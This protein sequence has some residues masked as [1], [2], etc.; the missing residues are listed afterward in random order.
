[1]REHADFWYTQQNRTLTHGGSERGS[2]ASIIQPL[3]KFVR[4]KF[5]Q[6]GYRE[7]CG[8]IEHGVVQSQQT[9]AH[10]SFQ[11][12]A[13]S[14]TANASVPGAHAPARR[15]ISKLAPADCALDW[16]ISS[17]TPRTSAGVT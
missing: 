12:G 2:T 15:G 7:G 11:Q 14:D 13:R 3:E 1:M 16:C 6:S 10:Q 9:L 17:Q 4:I 5:I 8:E